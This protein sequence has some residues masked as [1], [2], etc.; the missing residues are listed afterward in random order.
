MHIPEKYISVLKKT[1]LMK[2]CFVITAEIFL[3]K[4]LCIWNG[5]INGVWKTSCEAQHCV[6]NVTQVVFL[7]GLYQKQFPLK[8]A[9]CFFVAEH[10]IIF[11]KGMSTDDARGYP[12]C[13]LANGI[14]FHKKK[15]LQYL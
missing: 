7:P 2:I 8:I 15:D 9:G 5:N 1:I 3:C 4:T 14:N 10:A 13:E 6:L 11:C 12:L